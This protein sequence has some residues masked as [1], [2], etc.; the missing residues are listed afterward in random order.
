[1]RLKSVC[2]FTFLLLSTLIAVRMEAQSSLKDNIVSD[3]AHA[4]AL[5]QYHAYVSPEV[6]LYS[7]VQ[8]MDYDFTIQKG[9]PFFGPD[10]IRYGW[11]WYQ[12]VM[13]DQVRMLYDLVKDQ[14]VILGPYDVFKISL[15]MDRVDSFSI[16]GQLFMR[17]RDSLAPSALHSGYWAPVYRGRLVLLQR[18]RKFV[19]ENLVVTPDNVRLFIDGNTSYYLKKDGAYH[20]VNTKKDLYDLLNDRRRDIRRLIRRSKLKWH[21]DKE[22]LLQLAAS[23]YDGVNH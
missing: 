3:S 21:S 4:V 22:Q 2:F 15:Y 12:G 9:Q 10:S 13:Y 14:L 23:W 19:H 8:Y 1:M 7:G 5:R 16:D 11:V 18:E 20:P 17:I 6:G